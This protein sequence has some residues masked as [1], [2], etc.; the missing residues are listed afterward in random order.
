MSVNEGVPTS[1]S[2]SQG[3]GNDNNPLGIQHE[4]QSLPRACAVVI[5]MRR[6]S[7]PMA[8]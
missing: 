1:L 7:C 3:L 8:L 6:A 2:R 5:S 4:V